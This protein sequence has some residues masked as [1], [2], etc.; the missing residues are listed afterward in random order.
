MAIDRL[1]ELQQQRAELAKRIKELADRQDEWSAEDRGEWAEINPKYDAIVED[2]EKE[3]EA[4]DVAARASVI[5]D[6]REFTE[7]ES[8][9]STRDEKPQVREEHRQLAFSAWA[10]YQNG[11]NVTERHIEAAELCNVDFKSPSYDV[12]LT[13]KPLFDFNR[14]GFGGDMEERAQSVGTDSAGGYLVPQGFQAELEKTLL[15]YG[16]VRRVA[17]IVRTASGNDLP[18][19]TVDD[20]GNAGVLLAENAAISETAVTFGSKTFGAYKYSSGSVLVSSEL[21]TDSFTDLASEVGGMLGERLGRITSQHFTSGDG[22]S[23]PEGATVGSTAGITAASATAID[24]DELFNLI[25]ELDPAYRDS[26]SAGLMMKDSTLL[27]VRKLKDGND[28]YLWQEG[29]SVGEPDRL[30]GYPIVINQ[31]MPAATTGLVSILFGDWSKMIVRDVANVRVIR[32]D[33][34][35]RDNDQTGFIAFSRHDSG[36]IQSSAIQRMTMA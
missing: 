11:L 24:P 12:Q 4:H 23:K 14:N 36:V 33:E 30:L 9:R 15:A 25:H 7:W 18:W 2:Q 8:K 20:T 19:P 28:Q 26:P 6:A 22:S 35:Y 3:I 5:A 31:D 16:G 29:M 17:R 27:L 21:M 1:Q 34:R 13:P 10:R 32:L